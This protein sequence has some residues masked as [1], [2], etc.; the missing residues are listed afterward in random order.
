Y[1]LLCDEIEQD[2]LDFMHAL[3]KIALCSAR[4][5]H[6]PHTFNGRFLDLGFGTGVWAI[7]MEKAYPN[8]YVLGVD[9]SAIQPHF[10]PLNCVFEVPFDHELPWLIGEGRWD[11]IHMQI[12]C[13]SI[14]IFGHLR[15][16][17]WFEQL[18]VN[19]EPRCNDRP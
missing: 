13:G 18:E 8:A 15:C 4:V 14:R 7:E 2:H 6:V 11:V 5:I 12:E 9:M 1:M 10:R 19:F 16:D 17:I 3:F